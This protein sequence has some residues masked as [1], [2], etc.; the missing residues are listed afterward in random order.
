MNK[1]CL[2]GRISTELEVKKTST[3]ESLLDFNLAVKRDYKN[4]EGK[5]DVD[6]IHIKAWGGT[7]DY[8]ANYGTKGSLIEV[9]GRIAVNEYQNYEGKK[10]TSVYVRSDGAEILARPQEKKT[11]GMDRP[12]IIAASP[13]VGRTQT[14]SNGDGRDVTGHYDNNVK[15]DTD[16]LPFY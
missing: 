9:S 12:T 2:S 4:K 8:L 16:E 3:G 5:Y 13:I 1:V 11:D 10:V 7:A 6:F 14:T 15:I